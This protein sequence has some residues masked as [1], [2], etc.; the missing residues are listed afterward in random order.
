[1]GMKGR[2]AVSVLASLLVAAALACGIPGAGVGALASANA[3]E[4]GRTTIRVAWPDQPGLTET[5]EDGTHSGYTYDY[6]QQIA[7]Y[8]G[9]DYEYVHVEGDLNEQL[10]MLLDMVANGEVD[11]IGAMNYSDQLA[12]QYDFAI[13]AY[14][15]AHTALFASNENEDLSFTNIYTKDKLRAAF[16]GPSPKTRAA[17]QTF[18]DMNGI[19]LEAVTYESA[20]EFLKAL[21]SGDVDVLT[22]VDINL[23]G[24]AHVVATLTQTPFYFAATKGSPDVVA[25]LNEAIVQTRKAEPTLEQDLYDKY[26]NSYEDSTGL[27]RDMREYASRKGSVRIGY[28]PGAAP[29]QDVDEKTGQLVG[30]SQAVIDFI[31]DYTGLS[32]E[33]VP[34]TGNSSWVDDMARLDLDA[35][36]GVLHNFDFAQRHG[37]SLSTSY[38]TSRRW[39]VVRDGLDVADLSTKR[40]AVTKD[41]Y[42]PE[43]GDAVVCNTLQ[44]CIEAVDSG[45][46]DYTYTDGY[47]APYYAN[48]NR[49][50]NITSLAN[51]DQANDTCFA[52]APSSDLELIRMFNEA[53]RE[54]PRGAVNESIYDAVREEDEPTLARFVEAYAKELALVGLGVMLVVVALSVLYLRNSS[55]ALKI[56]RAEKDRLKAVADRDGLTNLL[57][58]GAFR[59]AVET[60]ASRGEVGGFAV[61]DVDDFKGVNDTYGH[62]T[63]DKALRTLADEL[64]KTFGEDDLICRFG[65]DEFAVCL[66]GPVDAARLEERCAKLVRSAAAASRAAGC[67]YT[68]S[69][70]A[71]KAA[72]SERY[73]DLYDRADQ[74]MY[75]AKRSGKGRSVVA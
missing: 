60:L 64:R 72:G 37:L 58:M 7:Q 17:V 31:A 69:V 1:M 42:V 35:V 57:A 20:D 41:A 30:A 59:K 12:E 34:L 54:M 10:T 49:Y 65:G 23:I 45:R 44:D 40:I 16:N 47:S 55:K 68:V 3:A 8:T 29:V 4:G 36:A 53:V 27:S 13:N 75:Q 2:R 66:V 46:A 43:I 51:S 9:W 22:G 52:F 50:R 74:V 19:E 14:G 5:A 70:G 15:S 73:Q 61:I 67:P 24:G 25:A 6:L 32:V 63:G 33:L 21:E 26:F 28:L 56:I 18:C 62:Q 11:I 38:L 48:E 39:T 71:V